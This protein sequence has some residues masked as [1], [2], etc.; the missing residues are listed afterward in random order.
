MARRKRSGS[1]P[2]PSGAN[3]VFELV[4]IPRAS[5][6]NLS[7]LEHIRLEM[8]RCY[9][10]MKGR[11]L[12]TQEGARLVWTLASIAKVIEASVIERRLA[13]LERIAGGNGDGKT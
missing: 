7:S 3:S 2:Q 8:S 5:A 1:T 6:V 12:D 13:E 10:A 9:R 11:T 4:P